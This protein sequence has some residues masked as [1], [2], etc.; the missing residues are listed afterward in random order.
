[1]APDKVQFVVDGAFSMLVQL[2][3]NKDAENFQDTAPEIHLC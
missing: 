2:L 3:E 1:M